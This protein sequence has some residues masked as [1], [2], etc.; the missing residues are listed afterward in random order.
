MRLPPVVLRWLG[1][2]RQKLLV[3][4]VFLGEGDHKEFSADRNPPTDSVGTDALSLEAAPSKDDPGKAPNVHLQTLT[5][6]ITPLFVEPDCT[7]AHLKQLVR[8]SKRITMQQVKLIAK[9]TIFVAFYRV[10]T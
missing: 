7:V 8:D 3:R 4:F 9:S 5:G 2:S 1:E 6:K 10:C